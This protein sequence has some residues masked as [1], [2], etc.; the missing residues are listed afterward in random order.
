MRHLSILFL[1]C[2]FIGTIHGQDQA[3]SVFDRIALRRYYQC[4]NSQ[5]APAVI[6]YYNP[7]NNDA[8]WMLS[9]AL[10]INVLPDT[11]VVISLSPYLEYHRNTL[12]DREQDN[13]QAGL[14]LEWQMRDMF[15]KKWSPILISSVK[16]NQDNENRVTSFMG[17]YYV[18]FLFKGKAMNPKY[19]WLPNTRV[20]FGKAFQFVYTPYIGLENENRS[21]VDITADEGSIYRA[22]F[23]VTS[24][25]RLFPKHET[26]A[27]RIEFNIDWQYRYNLSET[28]DNLITSDH[29]YFSASFDYLF[30]TSED[31]RKV[32]KI[33]FDY[34]NGDDPSKNFEDQSFYALSLKVRL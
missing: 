5:A 30:Y 4:Q 29:Q 26:L 12:I 8:S 2:S 24:N 33:G 28:V 6:T 25:I 13:F 15:E 23:R 7:K 19:F 18:T 10:G 16:Y 21:A 22:Y 17:N 1:M 14:A 34:T 11:D 32:V 3:R 9:A 20:N 27:D 31:G